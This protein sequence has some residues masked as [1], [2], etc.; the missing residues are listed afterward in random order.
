MLGEPVHRTILAIDVEGFT[1]RQR[2]DVDRLQMRRELYRLL[3]QA[4]ARAG[5]QTGDFQSEDRGD[6]I[7][8]LL[9]AEGPGHALCATTH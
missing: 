4:L 8:V 9:N 7:L 2:R 5:L 3:E 6:G 1:R